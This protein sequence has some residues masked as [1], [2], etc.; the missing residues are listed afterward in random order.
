MNRKTVTIWTPW[1][2]QSLD[3]EET[4]RSRFRK[5]LE[6]RKQRE[7]RQRPSPKAKTARN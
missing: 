4:S 2:A 1:G 7:D 3:R 6:L 5:R